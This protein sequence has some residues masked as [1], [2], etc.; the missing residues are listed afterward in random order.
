MPSALE[1]RLP[2]ADIFSN[3]YQVLSKVQI[4]AHRIPTT[5]CLFK[6]VATLFVLGPLLKSGIELLNRL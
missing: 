1:L 4:L 3:A 2:S 6:P 5:S